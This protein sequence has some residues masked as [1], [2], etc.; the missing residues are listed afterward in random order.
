MFS[1]GCFFV[2]FIFYFF[3]IPFF[4]TRFPTLVSVI[5][6]RILS[7]FN[8]KNGFVFDHEI[9]QTANEKGS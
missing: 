8:T 6:E 4:Q 9:G 2:L 5:F 1:E 7:L 3:L